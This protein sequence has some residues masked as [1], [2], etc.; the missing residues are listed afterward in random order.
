M[1][2]KRIRGLSLPGWLIWFILTATFSVIGLSYAAWQ[3]QL[4]V[5]VTASTGKVDLAITDCWFIKDVPNGN[6][7]DGQKKPTPQINWD[8]KTIS[9]SIEDARPGYNV[10]FG[11]TIANR[12]S[13]PVRLTAV[14]QGSFPKKSGNN[15]IDPGTIKVQHSLDKYVLEPGESTTGE[16]HIT[17]QGME[18]NAEYNFYFSL[19]FIQWNIS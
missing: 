18:E 13:L 1:K 17:I 5:N 7:P 19:D 4:T 16:I 3:D 8:G 14:N 11:Y 6:I 2:N 10:W 12:G 15:L 9:I